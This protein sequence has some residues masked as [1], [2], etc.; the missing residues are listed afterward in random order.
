VG[1]FFIGESILPDPALSRTIGVLGAGL[2]L[3][4]LGAGKLSIDM[5]FKK[6][7]PVQ[8]ASSQQP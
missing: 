7:S 8:E 1:G 3:W 6:R 2:A 4:F 5:W